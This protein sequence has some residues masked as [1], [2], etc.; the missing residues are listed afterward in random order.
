MEKS[1]KTKH[2]SNEE[3]MGSIGEEEALKHM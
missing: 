2:K 1:T 3:M